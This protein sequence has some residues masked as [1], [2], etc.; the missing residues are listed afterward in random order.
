MCWALPNLGRTKSLQ[1][2]SIDT[3]LISLDWQLPVIA[4]TACSHR[5]IIESILLVL[6]VVALEVI[7]WVVGVAMLGVVFWVVGVIITS[8]SRLISVR[9]SSITNSI[10]GTTITISVTGSIVRGSVT[11]IS[12]ICIVISIRSSSRKESNVRSCFM[13]SKSNATLLVFWLIVLV[14]LA[15][16]GVMLLVA[17]LVGVLGLV[18]SVEG[19]VIALLVVVV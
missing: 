12:I 7:W 11:I 9:S 8:I 19:I 2:Q 4:S 3:S 13:S 17:V 1:A 10:W 18:L 16:V 5:S 14:V 15:R 6:G